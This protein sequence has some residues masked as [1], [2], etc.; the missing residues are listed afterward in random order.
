MDSKNVKKIR[1]GEK[2]M[3]VSS[4]MQTFRTVQMTSS[5]G[6]AN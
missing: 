6:F 3:V 2:Q 5:D 1:S 4:A